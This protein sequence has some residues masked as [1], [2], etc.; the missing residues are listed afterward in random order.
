MHDKYPHLFSP[1]KLGPLTLRNRI[2]AAPMGVSD[3]TLEGFYTPEN[4]ALFEARAKGGAA[5]VTLGESSVDS[6]NG[7][8]SHGR[9]A[10]LDDEQILPSLI[11]TTDAIKRHGA[12]ASIELIHGGRRSHP[13]YSKSG[14]VYGPNAGESPYGGP[15]YAMDEALIEHTIEAFGEAAAM[16]KLGG[17]Q[18]CMIHG[19]HGW[20]LSQFLSPLNNQRTDH[21][22][23]S[24]ENR[25][26]LSL[27]VIESV[28]SKCGPN[29]PIEFRL[30]ADEFYPGGLTLENMIEFVKMIDGKVDLI[31]V[32]TATFHN[33]DAV[34]RMI[35]NM[36]YPRG[37]N[38]YLAEAIKQVVSTPVTI[39]GG[40]ND[41]VMMEEILASGKADVIVVGRAL[42]ADPNLPNKIRKGR[43]SDVTPCLRC[44]L[45]ISGS[46]VPYV[47]Y[48]T[49]VS[50]CMVNPQYG[51]E[52]E[53]RYAKPSNGRKKV[54]VIGGGPGG[55]QA[56]IV[57]A[58]RGHEVTLCEKSDALGGMLKFAGEPSFKADLEKLK[59]VLIRRVEERPIRV[60]LNTEGTPDMVRGAAPDSLVIAVG[61]DPVY[62]QLP[63]IENKNVVMAAVPHAD[64]I[65][66][67]KVVVIGGGLVGCEEGLHLAQQGKDVTIL[68]MLPQAAT[69]APFVHWRALMLELEKKASLITETR[70]TAI[71]DEG[72]IAV[73]A[74]GKEK[75]YP[76]DTVLVAVGLRPRSD[77]V[78]QLRDCAPDYAVVGDCSQPA[79]VMEAIHMGYFA[80]MNI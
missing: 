37:V 40:L 56:A 77:L 42:V 46:F 57:A 50:R 76:A 16:A 14:K 18:M 7:G 71:T 12:I 38:I 1:M 44:N 52:M 61:A 80:G 13:Q 4:V 55:M 54:M 35:P 68:E 29:F 59:N 34:Q 60:L 51:R 22:G 23:G 17:A 67:Q 66:G 39:L 72:V 70:C 6:Y 58:D 28:R 49:R 32:S 43:E 53:S 79:K 36:F 41:P 65:F 31:H 69:D 5:I 21:Y 27:R 25:A 9:V 30:S 75:L 15:V 45:C 78:D 62:P 8:S 48:A 47:R 2:E 63:G 10:P 64:A 74:E 73:D 11:E 24:L 19:G 3:L 33:R 26:R 20:L